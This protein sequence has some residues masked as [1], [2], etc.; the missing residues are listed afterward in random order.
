MH[1]RQRHRHSKRRRDTLRTGRM[2]RNSNQRRDMP[3]ISH[4]ERRQRK[5][6]E[7]RHT[8]FGAHQDPHQGRGGRNPP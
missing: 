7:Y 8:S 4:Q 6:P 2:Y 5:D 3:R 1:E